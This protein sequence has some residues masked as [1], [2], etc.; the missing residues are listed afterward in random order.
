MS[1]KSFRG[2][3]L[4]QG[5]QLISYSKSQHEKFSNFNELPGNPVTMQI[6]IQE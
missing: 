3:T 1:R 2:K 5:N 4:I 6:L